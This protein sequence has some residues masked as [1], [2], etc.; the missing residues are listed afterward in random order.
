MDGWWVG[1]GVGVGTVRPGVRGGTSKGRDRLG[2]VYGAAGD[3]PVQGAR[4]TFSGNTLAL[5]YSPHER[6]E[7]YAALKGTTNQNAATYPR[8]LQT[9]GDTV[10]GVKSGGWVMPHVALGGAG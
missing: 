5:A 7:L 10:F 4:N 3:L 6:V 1:G 2:R 8:L 9:Q